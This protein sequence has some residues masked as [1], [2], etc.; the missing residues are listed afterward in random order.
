MRLRAAGMD[1]VV[2]LEAG[3][4]VGGR[5]RTDVVDGFLLDRGFQIFLTSYPEVAAT[6]D[7]D[8]LELKPFYAGAKVWW[9]GGFHQVADPFRHPIDGV[10]S[11]ANPIGTVLDKILVGIFRFR[12]TLGSLDALYTRPEVT[13]AQRLEREGFSSVMADRFFRPFLGGIFFD[14]ALGTSSRHFEFVMRMLATGANCLPAKGIGAVVDQMAARLPGSC[15]HL[16][17]R[18]AVVEGQR[19]GACASVTTADGETVTA[20]KGVIVASDGP[21][22]QRLLGDALAKAGASKPQPGVGTSCL[23][24]SA[25]SP[26]PSTLPMLYLNGEDGGIV[27]NCCF[28]STIAPSYAPPGATLVSVSTIGTCDGMDE[29]ALEAAAKA[30]LGRWFGE[31]YVASW[32]L[33]RVY[34]IAFAQPNQAPPTD[35]TR[36][37]S[38]G[39]GL[40]VCGDHR[41]SAT[42]DG[43][44]VSGR[45]AADALLGKA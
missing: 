37:V 26:P 17:T 2:V 12:A 21:E 22:A 42:L 14:R 15:V 16:S 3:D 39:S 18:V 28:P 36:P 9:N 34:R 29:T 20:R 44:F 32:R 45:R 1:D 25:A 38:L 24:F 8:A 10:L 13:I 30:Q 23:Y 6:L 40:Y 27:N 7:Y 31:G 5:V 4:G 35:F 33:L 41:D 11:L 19:E 43:A